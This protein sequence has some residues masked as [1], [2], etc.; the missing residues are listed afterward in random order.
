[1]YFSCWYIFHESSDNGNESYKRVR[2]QKIYEC[3]TLMTRVMSCNNFGLKSF[4][5][6]KNK[7]YENSYHKTWKYIFLEIFSKF[8]NVSAMDKQ[9]FCWKPMSKFAEE[10]FFEFHQHILGVFLF[11]T[12][13]G[14]KSFLLSCL[15]VHRHCGSIIKINIKLSSSTCSP[16]YVWLIHKTS[17]ETDIEIPT[18]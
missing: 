11:S 18:L 13:I 8:F 7:F 16:L 15:P 10:N 14:G 4:Q 17:A 2:N 12:A 6:W 9:N 3:K 1:M 5:C